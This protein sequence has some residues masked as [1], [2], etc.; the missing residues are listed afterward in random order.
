MRPVQSVTG[1]GDRGIVTDTIGLKFASREW[2]SSKAEARSG[3]SFRERRKSVPGGSDENI[4][5]FDGL[6]KSHPIKPP[7]M[8]C[9]ARD[10]N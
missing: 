2:L 7:P 10:A 9:S 1:A 8:D 6:E 3:G 5:V 4:P